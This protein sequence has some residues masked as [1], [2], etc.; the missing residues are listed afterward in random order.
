MMMTAQDD[1][2]DDEDRGHIN[3]LQK[4][5]QLGPPIV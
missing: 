2:D 5:K 1:N 3:M 4:G